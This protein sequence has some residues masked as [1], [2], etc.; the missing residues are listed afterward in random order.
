MSI[1][2]TFVSPASFT[3]TADASGNTDLTE[4]CAVGTRIRADCGTDGVKYGVVTAVGCSEQVTTITIA[5]DALTANLTG[6]TH[7][8]ETPASLANHG[9][10]GIADGGKLIQCRA[11]ANFNGTAATIRASEN[12][13]SITNNGSGKYTV[14]FLTPM[15]DTNYATVGSGLRHQGTSLGIFMLDGDTSGNPTCYTT[16]AVAITVRDSSDK[17]ADATYV[18]IAVFR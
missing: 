11:W 13:S 3:A 5:G 17:A 2:A 14:N 10:T 7:G 8:N 12:V 15:S 9:H 4:Q 18:H 1:P 16:A 6:F